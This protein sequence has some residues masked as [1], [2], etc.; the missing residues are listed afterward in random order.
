MAL[1]VMRGALDWG[2]ARTARRRRLSRLASAWREMGADRGACDRVV[3]LAIAAG[4][5]GLSAFALGWTW[6]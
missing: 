4:L 5:I 1:V 2:R 3:G 6:W